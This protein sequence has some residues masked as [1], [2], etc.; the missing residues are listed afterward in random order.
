MTIDRQPSSPLLLRGATVVDGTGA[1]SRRADVL[2]AGDRIEAVGPG[3]A[4]ADAEVLDVGGLVVAPGF[5]DLH[6]HSDFTFPEYPASPGQVTQGVT[7]ELIGHCGSSPAPV[8]RDPERRRALIEY[9][10]GVGPTLRYRWHSFA[11][12]LDALDEVRPAVNCLPL[13]GHIPLRIAAMG[14][15]D[16][17]PTADEIATMQAGVREA[18]AAGAWGM[19]TGLSYAPGQWASREEVV[20]VARPLAEGATPALYASHIRNESDELLAAVEEALS[21]GEELGVPVRSPA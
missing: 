19:S 17:P 12:Y 18:L 15:A 5:I 10:L 7:S 2:I 16:R 4:A 14:M 6:F 3:L 21:I 13:V 11:E 9:D 8:S 1:P 20:A